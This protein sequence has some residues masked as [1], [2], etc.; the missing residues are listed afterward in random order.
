MAWMVCNRITRDIVCV[1]HHHTINAIFLY[2]CSLVIL[3]IFSLRATLPIYIASAAIKLLSTKVA[4][5][6]H[7]PF[8]LSTFIRINILFSYTY[9][10]IKCFVFSCTK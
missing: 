2:F 3:F 10:E 1:L 6:L 4:I 9:I 5:L 8:N 7:L